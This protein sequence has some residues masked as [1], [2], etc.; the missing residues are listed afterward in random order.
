MLDLEAEIAAYDYS[1]DDNLDSEELFLQAGLSYTPRAGY[2]VPTYSLALRQLEE[3]LSDDMMDASTTTVILSLS[4]R[5]NDR[6]SLLGGIKLGERDTDAG[7]SDVESLFVNYDYR[8]SPEW[9]LYTTLETGEG[10]STARS[11][12]SGVYAAGRGA[13]PSWRWDGNV[14][15]CDATSLTV[16]ASYVINAFNSLDL[17][18]GHQEYDFRSGDTDGNVYS[19]DYFHRF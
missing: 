18:F 3:F 1:D 19:V 4:Y 6:S 10:A 16:G 14:D 9:Q 17:S 8:I 7:D 13:G 5:L 12:C 2:R 15:D 11:Y